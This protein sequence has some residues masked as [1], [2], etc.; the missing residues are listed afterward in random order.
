M[1]TDLKK[2]II[3][4]LEKDKEFRYTIAGLI[5]YKELLD[6]IVNIEERLA[7]FEERIT[8]RLLK[9]EEMIV[10]IDERVVKIEERFADVNERLLKVEE[11][12]ADVNERLAK[13]DER[14]TERIVKLE[15]RFADIADRIVKIDERVVKIEER[16]VEHD[17]KFN[18]IIEEIKSLRERDTLL[19]VDMNEGFKRLDLKISALGARWGIMNEQSV[20]NALKGII[21]KD[22]GYK[23]EEFN[24]YD[25]EGY[26]YGYPS[27]IQLDIVISNSKVILVEISAHIKRSDPLIAKKKADIYYKKE[28]KK[29]DKILFVT[30]FR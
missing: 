20:R 12:I 24:I 7:K 13:I 21:E 23:A 19:I 3:E 17:K 4:L 2:S 11:R 14:I 10:K 5:G 22:L 1:Q 16:L 26:V 6:R 25:D 15:E 8:D 9:V 30:P 28:G 18:A 27:N 29:I